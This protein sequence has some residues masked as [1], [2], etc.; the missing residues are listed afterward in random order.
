MNWHI[1]VFTE[2]SHLELWQIYKS[3][4][5]VFVVEQNCP[6]PEVDEKDLH[7]LHVFA[8]QDGQLAA[9][10]RIIAE[11]VLVKIGRV[12]VVS[13][14]RELGLGRV[15]MQQALQA[16][17]QR[18]PQQEIHIQ[19]QLYLQRFYESL[20]FHKVSDEYLEDGIPHID[21]VWRKRETI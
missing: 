3:R 21:M 13:S 2:L 1:K 7:A 15:L 14:F 16:V 17:Q 6:Y 4:V 19:A 20:G 12:L 8:E 10:C 5:D 9:Y 11:E 18:F